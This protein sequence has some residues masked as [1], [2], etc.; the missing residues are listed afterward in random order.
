MSLHSLR[1][2]ARQYVPFMRPDLREAEAAEMAEREHVTQAKAV[3]A[4]AQ[5][6]AFSAVRQERDN[7]ETSDAVWAATERER[8]LAEIAAV[9]L[10]DSDEGRELLE[11]AENLAAALGSFQVAVSK[12]I[13]HVT[14]LDARARELGVHLTQRH[15]VSVTGPGGIAD[16]GH[17]GYSLQLLW[18]QASAKLARA[19]V[20]VDA[21]TV[22]GAGSWLLTALEAA[23]DTR[24][25][26]AHAA[27]AAKPTTG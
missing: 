15:R 13:D 18:R 8:V 3:H 25:R 9:D 7:L 23:L 17:A 19:V 2:L 16:A 26:S 10:L 20:D 5:N 22:R 11:S 4:S 1:G 21:P 6:A 12:K 14:A 24:D 27:R